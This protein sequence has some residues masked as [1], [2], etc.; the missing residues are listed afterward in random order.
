M[1]TR[2]TNARIMVV[3][4][5]NSIRR[6]FANHLAESGYET[7]VATD[8]TSAL[9]SL[10][11]FDP[12]LVITDV[13]MPGMSGLELLAHIKASR[14]DI[15]VVVMTAHED[16]RTAIDAM[17]AGAYDYLVKPLD[18]DHIDLVVERCLRDRTLRMRAA[19]LAETA[20]QPFS[21][22]RIV[23]RHPAMIAMYKLIGQVAGTRTPVLVRGETGTGK[24]LVARAVHYNSDAADQPFVALNCTA[25]AE[26]LLESELFGHTRG[27]FTGAI[28]DRKGRFELAG[29]GTLFLDEIGDTSPG[30]QAKLLRVLQEHEFSPVGSERT[31][32]TEARVIAATNRN[33]EEAVRDSRFREDLYYRLRVVEMRVPALRERRDDIAL[34]AAHFLDRMTR[35][36]H[37]PPM[38]V[39]KDAAR[40]LAAYDWPGNVRELENTMARAMVLARGGV[41]AVEHLSLGAATPV[42]AEDTAPEDETLEAMERAHVGRVLARAGWNKRQAA[43][44]LGISRPT[45]DRMIEKYGIVEGTPA[46]SASSL[47]TDGNGT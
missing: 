31:R 22:D 36:Q 14:P 45:L 10:G 27:A 30:F 3:D 21:L 9:A 35:E 5:D 47:Y 4:D 1:S 25:V 32:R 20:A 8:A 34:L 24:E 37:A 23:G 40:A 6:T 42:T 39:S 26:T 12:A 16:M 17:K 15:D 41:I 29:R 18:L 46:G 43:Q 33:L 28:S 7:A 44:R 38:V 11:A 19:Q 13:R 2:L